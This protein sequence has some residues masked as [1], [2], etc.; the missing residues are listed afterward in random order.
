[1]SARARILAIRLAEKVQENPTVA[2]KLGISAKI[3]STKEQQTGS[4]DGR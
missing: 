3:V 2:Q 1:M 4:Q